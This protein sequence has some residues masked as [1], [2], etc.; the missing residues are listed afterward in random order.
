MV[1]G[2]PK[3]LMDALGDRGSQALA[4]ENFERRLSEEMAKVNKRITEE[5]AK[6]NKRITEETA[7]LDKRITEEVSKVYVHISN[8]FSRLLRWMFAFWATTF[9]T[10]IGFLIA[11]LSVLKGG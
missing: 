11:L 9:V 10:L 5:V 7:K 3:E 6:V 1:V 2:L 4:E 8:V